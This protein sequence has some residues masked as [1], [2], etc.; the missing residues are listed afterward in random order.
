MQVSFLGQECLSQFKER[1][2][3][4]F[5]GTSFF[6]FFWHSIIF[7]NLT[8]RR[9]NVSVTHDIVHES[10]IKLVTGK[11][12]TNNKILRI[13]GVMEI[14]RKKGTPVR[15][16]LFKFSGQSIFT[17]TPSFLVY[18]QR[19]LLLFHWKSK[20]VNFVFSRIGIAEN[21]LFTMRSISVNL[22]RN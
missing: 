16:I 11:K 5:V 10:K 6:L 14:S 12:T 20:P 1:V 18:F 2:Q 19:P 3:N 13:S 22:H 4:I 8:I 17:L 15:N 7:L 9:K 21:C